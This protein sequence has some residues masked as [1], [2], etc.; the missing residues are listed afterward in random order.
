MNVD[1]E[2]ELTSWTA[3]NPERKVGFLALDRN[4]NG[5]IDNSSELFGDRTPLPSGNKAK[6]GWEA[7]AVFDQPQFGG[8]GNGFI[9]EKDSVFPQL[10]LWIDKNHNGISE[11]EELQE[12]NNLGIVSISLDYRE[13]R[14]VD[15]FGNI[16]QYR[17][18]VYIKNVEEARAN[19]RYAWDVILKWGP[20]R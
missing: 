1:G 17:A 3:P 4:E 9:D 18:I 15:R 19:P 14:R 13:S 20:L 5:Y 10:R 2:G 16:F 11:L 6:N 12:L 8:N 7:L